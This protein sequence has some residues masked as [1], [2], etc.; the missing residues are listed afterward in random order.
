MLKTWKLKKV[1]WDKFHFDG[2]N[3]CEPIF[4]GFECTFFKD[5]RHWSSLRCTIEPSQSIPLTSDPCIHDLWT[6]ETFSYAY[7]PN[8]YVEV[9]ACDY[10][11]N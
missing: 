10:I 9:G 11:P 5:E 2:K 8:K 6:L 3:L 1:T 4:F 7:I